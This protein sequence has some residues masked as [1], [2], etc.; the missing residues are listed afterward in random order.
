M[1]V[2]L[3]TYRCPLCEG[4][5]RQDEIVVDF[6]GDHIDLMAQ[7]DIRDLLK[8]F[9]IPDT[10]ARV[11]GRA[12]DQHFDV[13]LSDLVLHFL[14]INMETAVLSGFQAVLHY[15]SVV[16]HKYILKGMIDRLHDHDAVPLLRQSAHS[17][18][19]GADNTGDAD[20]PLL[21]HI[22]AVAFQHPGVDGFKI[23]IVHTGIAEDT[24]FSG[25]RD[26][27]TDFFG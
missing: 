21:F 12:E 8:L 19:N 24:E 4:V 13:L 16:G 7:T 10:A 20:H 15:L 17:R 26:H 3:L 5:A 2:H 6:I 25:L 23:I 11:V 22:P 18:G 14:K 1:L 9:L 27:V